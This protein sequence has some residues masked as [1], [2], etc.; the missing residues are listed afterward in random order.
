MSEASDKETHF[1]DLVE[2]QDT[3]HFLLCRVR[4]VE[5]VAK[6]R[7]RRAAERFAYGEDEEARWYRA[8]AERLEAEA[9]EK[10]L[11]VEER[12]RQIHRQIER[13]AS[14]VSASPRLIGS[15]QQQE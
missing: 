10:R 1:A 2:E 14:D 12:F 3:C 15:N 6:N 4:V 11:E 13:R 9:Q 5:D 7:R 8:E